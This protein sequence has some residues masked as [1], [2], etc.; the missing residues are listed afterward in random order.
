ML[1]LPLQ[2]KPKSTQSPSF[3]AQNT[4]TLQTQKTQHHTNIHHR[5]LSTTHNISLINTKSLS[6]ISPNG[7]NTINLSLMKSALKIPSKP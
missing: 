4:S 2:K 6:N 7:R 1:L 5:I 3:P